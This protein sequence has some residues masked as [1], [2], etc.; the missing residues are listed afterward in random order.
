[1]NKYFRVSISAING[2]GKGLLLKLMHGNN[3]KIKRGAIMSPLSEISLDKG[4]VCNIG[5]HFKIRGGGRIRVR[6]NA[7]LDIKNNVFFNHNCM[8][9]CQNKITIGDEV[10]FGPNVF[11]Y[12]HDHD[13]KDENGL[14]SGK[15]KVGTIEIGNNVWIGANSIILRNTKIGNNCVIAAGSVIKGEFPDN[16]VVYQEENTNIKKYK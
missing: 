7:K 8:I 14:K 2:A 10:Q 1:M 5:E 3:F 4:S 16:T 13:Y 6:K 12:D 11:L 9:V 15:F